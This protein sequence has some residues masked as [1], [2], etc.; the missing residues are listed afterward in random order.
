MG[1]QVPVAE[2]R[3]L[4][5]WAVPL[6]VGVAVVMVP[7]ATPIAAEVTDAAS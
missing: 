6:I 5:T 2:V 1:D 7:E 4:P 3:T